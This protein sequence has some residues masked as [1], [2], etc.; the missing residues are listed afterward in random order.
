MKG[1]SNELVTNRT[2]SMGV[3]KEIVKRLMLSFYMV[4]CNCMKSVVFPE[5]ESD[6]Y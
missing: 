4:F 2:E 5:V 3:K 1:K 6:S